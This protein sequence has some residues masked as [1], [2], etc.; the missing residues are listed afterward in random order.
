MRQQQA[1]SILSQPD[2]LQSGRNSSDIALTSPRIPSRSAHF[3]GA[4][5]V[6]PAFS[7]AAAEALAVGGVGP[8]AN[9]LPHIDA[10]RGET[11]AQCRVGARAGTAVP[12][13][14]VLADVAA[15]EPVAH[16]RPGRRRCPAVLDGQVRDAAAGIELVGRGDGAGRAGVDAAPARAA[17][18]DRRLIG[19]QLERGD[20]LA[21]QQPRAD[22]L[23]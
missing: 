12:R 6:S 19:R 9:D 8:T 4:P 3:V 7:T 10:C 21:Q 2:F 20:D 13:A 15:V 14:D 23:S 22:V 11:R 17:A 5:A 1:N 18:V 16:P